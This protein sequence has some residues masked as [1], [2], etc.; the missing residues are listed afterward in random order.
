M[1]LVIMICKDIK[2]KGSFVLIDKNKIEKS[3]NKSYDKEIQNQTNIQLPP[4][5]YKTTF[6]LTY[7][8]NR[9]PVGW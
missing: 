4:Y 1:Q 7:L 5:L 2:S 6:I 9:K 3:S 8:L